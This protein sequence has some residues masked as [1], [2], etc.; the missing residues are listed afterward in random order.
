[1]PAGTPPLHQCV[2]S[3]EPGI[4]EDTLLGPLLPASEPL[5]LASP[6]LPVPS[7]VASPPRS[8]GIDPF[9]VL[10]RATDSIH[11]S[12]HV[13][14]DDEPGA[15]IADV[16]AKVFAR[17]VA[18]L[19]SESQFKRLRKVFKVYSDNGRRVDDLEKYGPRGRP[20]AAARGGTGGGGGG[21]CCGTN[22]S[23]SFAPERAADC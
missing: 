2:D 16:Q 20:A 10:G 21:H 13:F 9:P 4:V 22:P 3:L 17:R 7:P 8:F 1:M 18:W 11:S 5:V 6:R 19:L 14:A 15:V 12:L 23:L